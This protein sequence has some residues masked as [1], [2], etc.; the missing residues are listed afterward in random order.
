MMANAKDTTGLSQCASVPR[1]IE[2]C[3]RNI[4]EGLVVHIALI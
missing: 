1:E 4:T 2:N 3:R